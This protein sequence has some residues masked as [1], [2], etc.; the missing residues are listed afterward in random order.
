MVSAEEDARWLSRAWG[1][2]GA[3]AAD[4]LVRLQELVDA[5]ATAGGCSREWAVP[6]YFLGDMESESGPLERLSGGARC[7]ES[8]LRF[9]RRDRGDLS[10]PAAGPGA[11]GADDHQQGRYE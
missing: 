4:V 6:A 5:K 11:P 2:F 1:A 10:Q 9:C 3:G 8:R 7:L